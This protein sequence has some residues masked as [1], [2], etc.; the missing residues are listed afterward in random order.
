MKHKLTVAALALAVA[1]LAVFPAEADEEAPSLYERLGGLKS[2][3]PMVD[4][5]I[6]HLLVNE[7]LNK[8]SAIA[9]ERRHTPP[10][11]LKFQLSQLICEMSGGPCIYSGLTLKEAFVPLKIGE[12]EWAVVAGEFKKTLVKFK[13]PESEQQELINL[14]TQTKADIVAD[15]SPGDASGAET[16]AANQQEEAAPA[17]MWKVHAAETK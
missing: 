8:N 2:I 4:D 17:P 12:H 10:P 6:N 14:V 9:T 1:P 7:T 15:E 3:T 13:V 5:F 11:Y 16:T